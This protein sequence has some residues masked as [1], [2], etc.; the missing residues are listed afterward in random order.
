M[1]GLLSQIQGLSQHL[2]KGYYK[3]RIGKRYLSEEQIKTNPTM[4]LADDCTVHFTPVVV[5]AGKSVGFVQAIVG[6][7]LIA[8]AWWNPLGWTAGTAMMVGAMG[9]SMAM[10]GVMQ[11]LARPP[12]MNTKLSDSEKQQSTSFSNIRNLTPQGRPIPLLY[13]KMM[14]SL[15]LISQGIDTFDDVTT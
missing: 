3:V 6:V 13:G 12:D 10:G 4:T 2:R 1:S 7:A 9:A 11:M 14:T 8:V 15:I 5:G